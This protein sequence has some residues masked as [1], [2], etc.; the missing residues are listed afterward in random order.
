[1]DIKKAA[2]EELISEIIKIT[3]ER[4]AI[5][6]RFYVKNAMTTDEYNDAVVSNCSMITA[7]TDEIK[8]RCVVPDRDVLS[9]FMQQ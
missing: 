4:D 2:L 9:D 3:H 1:M 5:Y 7:I 8:S 6:N